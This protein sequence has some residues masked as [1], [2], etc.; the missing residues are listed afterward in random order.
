MP[1]AF[2]PTEILTAWEAGADIVKVFPADV[3]GPAFF[4]AVR[5][6]VAADSPDADRRRRSEHGSRVPQGGRLLP[7][8][9]QPTRRAEGG[10]RP[11]FRPHPRPGPAI[12]RHRAA[13]RKKVHVHE[14]KDAKR[15][16][17]I[18]TSGCI[19]VITFGEAMIRLSPPNF[20][21]LEQ[22][23]QP[24]LSSRRR[25]IEHRGRPW[26]GWAAQPPGCRA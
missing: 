26:P 22:A 1:G 11:Q 2:T 25:G 20:Q 17:T 15:S 3:V 4:K 5:G 9:R 7:G 18:P 23:D 8:H 6:P 19:D 16:W 21:R 10:R 12:C 24:R 13:I 14:P